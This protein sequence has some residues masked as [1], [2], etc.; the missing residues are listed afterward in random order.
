MTNPNS[1]AYPCG[2]GDSLTKR[3]LFAAMALQGILSFGADK[4]PTAFN[5]LCK[6]QLIALHA[7][8]Y[9]D[10]LIETLNQKQ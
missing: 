2:A 8:Q 4:Y 9:A 3:E 6:E 5:N 7:V 1:A 10:H